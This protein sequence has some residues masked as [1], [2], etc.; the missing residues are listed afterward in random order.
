MFDD[1][2]QDQHAQSILSFA[3]PDA[4]LRC[5]NIEHIK[6][7]GATDKRRPCC[8]HEHMALTTVELRSGDI[9]TLS[10]KWR[11]LATNHPAFD[12]DTPTSGIRQ[13]LMINAVGLEA[14]M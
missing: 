2:K 13:R 6:P 12:G 5:P 1:K 10:P 3:Q 8:L 4:G 14:Q 9:Q 11:S 7:K